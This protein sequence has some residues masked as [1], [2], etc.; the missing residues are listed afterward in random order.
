MPFRPIASE[1][2]ASGIPLVEPAS[3][4]APAAKTRVD[5]VDGAK[6]LAILLVALYHSGLLLMENNMAPEVWRDIGR[7]FATFRMPLFFLAAGLFAGSVIA[8]PW[9]DLWNSRLRLLVWMFAL[10]TFIRF[11]YFAAVPLESRLGETGLRNLV[12]APIIPTSGLWFLHALFFFF[13]VAKVMKGRIPT[14]IQIGA[15]A[16]L[17]AAFLSVATF[18]SLSYNGMAR[19]FFFF[20]L[21][22]Y[23]K[24]WILKAAERPRWLLM[25]GMTALFA[26]LATVIYGQHLEL[27]PG[28]AFGLS[29]IAVSAGILIARCLAATPLASSLAFM[30]K[31]T[32]PIYVTNV[33]VIA[34]IITVL[35]LLPA[36]PSAVAA[37]L[38]VVVAALT[39][40]IGLLVWVALR[41][42]L[43]WLYEAPRFTRLPAARK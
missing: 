10:W 34:A 16:G 40:A 11:G 8:R 18:N 32:L 12:L 37:F 25:L 20:L 17:S 2:N 9:R 38:P 21:G 36:L 39:V 3:S 15:A 31:N 13:V 7:I 19:Y 24:Q 27:I 6:G 29:L 22:C 4:A 1:G 42:L 35:H 33:I 23:G 5:W 26:V 41:N 14:P 28:V 43:P 30:G